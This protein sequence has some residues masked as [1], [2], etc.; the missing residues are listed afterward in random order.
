MAEEGKRALKERVVEL[1]QQCDG[2]KRELFN[3]YQQL[4]SQQERYFDRKCRTK[5]KLQEARCV[6]TVECVR[7]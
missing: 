2:I 7:V 5:Y 6:P 3:A 4:S 1:E